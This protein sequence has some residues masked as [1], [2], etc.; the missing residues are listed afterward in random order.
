MAAA[1]QRAWQRMLSGRR[2]DLLDPSP[3]DV[4]MLKAFITNP[5]TFFS[6]HVIRETRGFIKGQVPRERIVKD[7]GDGALP[8]FN[9]MTTGKFN[10][11]PMPD[12]IAL[13]FKNEFD[14][15]LPQSGLAA[16][17]QEK[18]RTLHQQVQKSKAPTAEARAQRSR[19]RA[20]ASPTA[21]R[22]RSQC[23]PLRCG[24]RN[25]PKRRRRIR[26]TRSR[27]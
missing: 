27:P 1:R 18:L 5:E 20:C 12:E 7:F 14:A 8:L 16:D 21:V 10:P 22:R 23:N 3:L 6:P 2:L 26:R 19:R 4:E 15:L 11:N 17:K 9:D 25:R 13:A 24:R